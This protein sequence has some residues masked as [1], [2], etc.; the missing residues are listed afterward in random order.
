MRDDDMLDLLILVAIVGFGFGLG[1]GVRELISRRRRQRHRARLGDRSL[2]PNAADPNPDERP[3]QPASDVAINLD[4]LLA[5]ANDDRTSR[6]QPRRPEPPIV[7]EDR[8][9]EDDDIA[10]RDLLVE[11]NRLSS[12]EQTPPRGANFERLGQNRERISR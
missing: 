5:A 3:A 11:L 1:Y 12:D 7:Q 2:G 10:V 4:R 8:R 6:Q 9:D